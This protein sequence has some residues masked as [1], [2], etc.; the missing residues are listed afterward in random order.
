[1]HARP[2]LNAFSIDRKPQR[3][4]ALVRASLPEIINKHNE[5]ILGVL[6]DDLPATTRDYRPRSYCGRMILS[7]PT[8]G[9][10]QSD[11][12]LRL[13]RTDGLTTFVTQFT[14]GSH[15][16]DRIF[17][18]RDRASAF[19]SYGNHDGRIPPAL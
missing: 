11:L 10:R 5:I 1:M 2:S 15:E 4:R 12:S 16:R 19:L 7:L 14:S 3:V 6:L 13:Y 17:T 9:D 8:S 18:R